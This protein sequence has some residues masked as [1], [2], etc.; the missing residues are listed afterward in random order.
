[1]LARTRQNPPKS[2]ILQAYARDL[3][4]LPLTEQ[5]VEIPHYQHSSY[6]VTDGRPLFTM[7]DHT[8]APHFLSSTDPTEPTIKAP[9][10]FLRLPKRVYT[11]IP[12]RLPTLLLQ[13]LSSP[14]SEGGV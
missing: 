14:T 3:T 10:H 5:H 6:M 1:M 13:F 9:V 11:P 8:H 2:P 7:D 12:S 4:T